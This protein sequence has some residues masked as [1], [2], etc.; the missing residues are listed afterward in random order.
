VVALRQVVALVVEV[1]TVGR[2]ELSS[3]A[4]ALVGIVLV[5]VVV[6]ED[7]VQ[8][9]AFVRLSMRIQRY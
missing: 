6:V 5:V 8:L 1:V 3:L 9:E 7:V 2:V 4:Q